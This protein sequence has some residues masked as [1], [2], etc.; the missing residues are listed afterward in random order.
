MDDQHLKRWRRLVTGFTGQVRVAFA[1]A[2]DGRGSAS[3]VD[4]ELLERRL[5]LIGPSSLV[6]SSHVH[7]SQSINVLLQ[8]SGV[9]SRVVS[10]HVLDI[11]TGEHLWW[12]DDSDTHVGHVSR[13]VSSDAVVYANLPT[14]E[15][16]DVVAAVAPEGSENWA[17]LQ[18]LALERTVRALPAG[19]SGVLRGLMDQQFAAVVETA[20]TTPS[21]SAHLLPAIG[22]DFVVGGLDGQLLSRLELIAAF[23][24]VTRIDQPTIAPHIVA[25]CYET[26]QKIADG[27]AAFHRGEAH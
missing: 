21:A 25:D 7:G 3:S 14:G 12:S 17:F 11:A 8:A 23:N 4:T 13:P 18:S 9:V 6:V 10:A 5:T 20:A 19:G 27:V 26:L 2:L 1:Q 22:M 24:D 15:P 16:D